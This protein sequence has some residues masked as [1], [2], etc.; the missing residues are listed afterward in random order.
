MKT[1]IIA[2]TDQHPRRFLLPKEKAA[3][4]DVN[5][6][7]IYFQAE[8]RETG[9]TIDLRGPAFGGPFSRI[10]PGRFI[11]GDI[12]YRCRAGIA[13][14]NQGRALRVIPDEYVEEIDRMDREIQSLCKLREEK[15]AEAW[16]R[17]R[18]LRL[19]DLQ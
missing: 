1:S 8:H 11:G 18:A 3:Q 7:T 4:L 13:M 6:K 2:G 12:V 17:G 10:V 9:S 5:L 16:R 14:T 15:I 19:S